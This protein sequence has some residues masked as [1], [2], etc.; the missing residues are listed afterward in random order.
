MFACVILYMFFKVLNREDRLLFIHFKY[1]M[2][3]FLV[4]SKNGCLN[5]SF[6]KAFVIDVI[7]LFMIQHII[8]ESFPSITPYRIL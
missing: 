8:N 2:F 5:R 7:L 6:L 3:C 4:C 1:V